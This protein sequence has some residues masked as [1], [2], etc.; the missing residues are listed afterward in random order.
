MPPEFVSADLKGA[1]A[2]AFKIWEDP[3]EEV[4]G[5]ADQKAECSRR[6]ELRFELYVK[7][8]TLP[9]SRDVPY[10][11][12]ARSPSKLL[13]TESEAQ[14]E[15]TMKSLKTLP[16]IG[17][18][19]VFET[20]QIHLLGVLDSRVAWPLGGLYSEIYYQELYAEIDHVAV[21]G[22][23]GVFRNPRLGPQDATKLIIG[24]QPVRAD[25]RTTFMRPVSDFALVVELPDAFSAKVRAID[26]AAGKGFED[27]IK[28]TLTPQPGAK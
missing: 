6:R 20:N 10:F 22:L 17:A 25:W 1:E 9:K 24:F 19:G 3:D 12:S 8:G 14:F 4:C 7:S 26:I 15:S 21:Q 18:L 23:T 27:L 2:V 11:Q 28:R 13:I 5:W 16:R